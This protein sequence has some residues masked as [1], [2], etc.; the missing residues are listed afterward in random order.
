MYL[1]RL[2]TKNWKSKIKKTP[3][4]NSFYLGHESEDNIVKMTVLF[5]IIFRPNKSP[6]EMPAGIYLL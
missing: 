5:T 6:I 4:H 1:N 2:E 3:P